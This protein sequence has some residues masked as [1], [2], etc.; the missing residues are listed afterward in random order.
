MKRK[1][2][3]LTILLIMIGL[4]SGCSAVGSKSSSIASVYA[5]T[6]VLSV[7][8]LVGYC[9]LARKREPWYLLLFASVLVVSMGYFTLAVSRNLEEALMANRIAYLGSVFLPFAMLMIILKV[10]RMQYNPRLPWLLLT[11]CLFVFLVAASPSFLDIYYQEVSFAVINGATVLNKVYGPWHCLYLYYLLAY[12]AAMIGA[13]IY[14]IY[15][16]RLDDPAYAIILFIAVSVN[17]GVWFIE[18]LVNINFEFLSVSYIISLLFLVS[19]HSVMSENARLRDQVSG[20]S[21]APAAEAPEPPLPAPPQP[22]AERQEQEELAEQVE[23]FLFGLRELTPA[24]R[25][26]YEAYIIGTSTK[27]IMRDLSIKENTLKYHNRNLYSKLGV[28]SRKQLM[29]VYKRLP[30]Q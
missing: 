15:K 25:N 19:V 20:Q 11:V 23:R 5:F 10:S 9:W 1:I 8:L 17:L 26:I 16:H 6:A 2:A 28:S 7:L 3:F 27:D 22:A 18:Q 29:E 13:I 24:E 30:R 21:P 12:Y 4:L 14:A